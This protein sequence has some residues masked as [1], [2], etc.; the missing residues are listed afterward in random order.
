MVISLPDCSLFQVGFMNDGRIVAADIQY[1][2]NAG[3]TVDESTMVRN[4][5]FIYHSTLC[6]LLV[7][8][9]REKNEFLPFA[10]NI[11]DAA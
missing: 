7:S 8:L 6:L 4:S 11:K 2:S 9:L 1:Y 3:N 5:G 10:D